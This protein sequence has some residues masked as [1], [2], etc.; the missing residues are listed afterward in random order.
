MS[1]K[2]FRDFASALADGDDVAAGGVLTE[3]LG[4]DDEGAARA[5][6]HFRAQLDASPQFM[7][8]AMGMR[9]VVESRDAARLG[10]LLEECFGLDDAGAAAGVLLARYD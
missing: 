1:E 8:K 9:G 2:T 4:L 3:L 10:A 7:M 5:T 6:A